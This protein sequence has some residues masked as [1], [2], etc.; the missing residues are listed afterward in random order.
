MSRVCPLGMPEIRQ[1]AH[2][3]PSLYSLS[4][5]MSKP[6]Q[7]LRQASEILHRNVIR[8]LR[9]QCGAETQL[10]FQVNEALQFFAAA[11]LVST[12]YFHRLCLDLLCVPAS[13]GLSSGRV[14]H[15]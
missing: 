6:L 9:T 1:E 3:F 15:T 8:T 12:F 4:P 11:Q 10:T 7:N 13:G 14:C 2:F 5:L